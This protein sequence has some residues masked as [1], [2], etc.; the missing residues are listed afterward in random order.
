[1]ILRE[2]LDCDAKLKDYRSV[3]CRSCAARVR[4]TGKRFSQEHKKKIAEK[5]KFKK[6]NTYGH[7]FKKDYRRIKNIT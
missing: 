3:R 2:C 5:S 4:Q 1:M 6:G 7:R